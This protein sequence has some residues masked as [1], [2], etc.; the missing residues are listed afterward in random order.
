HPSLTP[1]PSFSLLNDP[2][3]PDFSPLSLH[4]ALPIYDCCGAVRRDVG[5]HADHYVDDLRETIHAL[6][7][8]P[9]G[10]DGSGPDGGTAGQ[11]SNRSEEHT[12]ELQSLTNLVCR[13][14]LEKKKTRP[15]YSPP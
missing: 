5:V 7:L 14:L 1:L 8:C 12:S 4:D 15:P 2:P 10:R 6:L 11:R 9:E 3:P 13:L